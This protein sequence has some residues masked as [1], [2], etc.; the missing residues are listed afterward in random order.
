[1]LKVGFRSAESSIHTHNLYDVLCWLRVAWSCLLV[2]QHK[3]YGCC[4]GELQL[5]GQEGQQL[6]AGS[7]AQL[8]HPSPDGGAHWLHSQAH[9]PAEQMKGEQAR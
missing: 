7:Q 8:V 4:E 2:W 3:L 5:L 9:E 1:M 6:R